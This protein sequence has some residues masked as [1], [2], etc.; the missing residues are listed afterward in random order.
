MKVS[1]YLA[2]FRHPKKKMVTNMM[3]PVFGGYGDL[4]EQGFNVYGVVDYRTS[5]MI[6][7]KDRKVSR[8]GCL[9]SRIKYRQWIPLLVFLLT[10]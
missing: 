4:D 7:A 5:D 6:M 8:R 10:C 2:A 1:G 3:F 9:I